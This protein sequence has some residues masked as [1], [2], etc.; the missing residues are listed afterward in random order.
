MIVQ[1]RLDRVISFDENTGVLE[2]ESG[3]SLDEIIRRL[4]PRGWFLPTT[5]GTR[6]VTIGG[7]IAADVHGKNHHVDG[8]F[9][10]FV[11]D[12]KLMTA[13]GEIVECSPGANSELF[14]ATIGGMGL[15]G[16]I[17]SA[18][19]QL[20]KTESAYCEVEYRRTRDLDVAIET[21]ANNESEYRYSVAW[22]DCLA[23]GTSLGRSVVM[24]ANDAPVGRLPQK[25]RKQ[26]FDVPRRIEK[27]IPCMLPNFVMNRWNNRL[28]NRLYY[29]RHKDGQ[30]LVDY[31]SFFY[32]LDAVRNW[33]RMYGRRE[34]IQYQAFFPRETARRGLVELMEN[35]GRSRV[36]AFLGVLKSCGPAS[37]GL[38]SF[39]DSGFT[40]ALD[41]PNTG[42]SLEELTGAL[43]EV[44]LKHGGRLYLAK[45]AMTTSAAFS[46]MYPRLDKFLAIKHRVDPQR[47]FVSSQSRRVGLV[48]SN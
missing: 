41:F 24:L 26:P 43:D 38:L 39:L 45:D 33:N 40:L 47:R 18:R 3:V 20:V 12:L 11:L 30:Q 23:D 31:D 9:G 1:T 13:T 42:T 37:S 46:E 44:L 28:L 22:V 2:C 29:S 14:Q 19:I 25:H 4:L 48:P 32:P 36:P 7:A 10:R 15:T 6:F 17:V 35:V 16:V 8:S 34:F 21:L 5:P 27:P